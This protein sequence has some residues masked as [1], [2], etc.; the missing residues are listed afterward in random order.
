MNRIS[1]FIILSLLAIPN[2]AHA[3]T[4]PPPGG[5]PS[6]VECSCGEATGGGIGQGSCGSGQTAYVFKATLGPH[7]VSN[8]D[9]GIKALNPTDSCAEYV[10]TEIAK[11]AGPGDGSYSNPVMPPMGNSADIVWNVGNFSNDTVSRTLGCW[12]LLG[13]T[14]I[15][16]GQLFYQVTSAISNGTGNAFT[17]TGLNDSGYITF[18]LGSYESNGWSFTSGGVYGGVGHDAAT[19]NAAAYITA[20]TGAGLNSVTVISFNQPQSAEVVSN[21]VANQRLVPAS[22]SYIS[23]CGVRDDASTAFGISWDSMSEPWL[24][25]EFFGQQVSS[26]CAAAR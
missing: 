8:M 12:P 26:Y 3:L 9:L 15:G 6:G 20:P 4:C 7:A 5:C 1:I 2:L 24:S 18:K 16:G 25:Y 19:G 13:V 10:C 11:A 17:N 22:W 21:N 23:A 14:W